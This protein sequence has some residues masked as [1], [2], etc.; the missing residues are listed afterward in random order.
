MLKRYYYPV[1]PLCAMAAKDKNN[2]LYYVN[3]ITVVLTHV[4]APPAP[5]G[6]WLGDLKMIPLH[7]HFPKEVFHLL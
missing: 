1:N 2:N 6:S 7:I 5:L 3:N 4:L